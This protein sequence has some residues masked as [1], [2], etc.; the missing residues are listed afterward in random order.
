MSPI[1]FKEKDCISTNA[2]SLFSLSS[3]GGQP[4]RDKK[5]LIIDGL[6]DEGQTLINTVSFMRKC[7]FH[8]IYLLGTPMISLDKGIKH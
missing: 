6:F 7:M 1:F 8:F 4:D 2:N 3:L 5:R